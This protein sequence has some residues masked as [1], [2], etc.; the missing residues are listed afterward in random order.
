MT[1]PVRAGTWTLRLPRIGPVVTPISV[2][3]GISAMRD[4]SS[5]CGAR[6]DFAG[7]PL[8][9]LRPRSRAQVQRVADQDRPSAANTGP[10]GLYAQSRPGPP[11]TAG[12]YL[13]GFQSY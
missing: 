3:A 12:V 7:K 8:P 2:F 5:K 13:G 11:Q 1:L 6:T 4:R 9:S 10:P